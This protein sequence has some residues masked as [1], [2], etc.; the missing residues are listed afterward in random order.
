MNNKL[1]K[2]FALAVITLPLLAIFI[3]RVNS[4]EA[5]SGRIV[6]KG[7]DEIAEA[8]KKQCALCHKAT[9]EKFFNT[10]LKDEELVQA[11][12]KGKKAEKPP[13]MPEFESKGVT[14]EKAKLFVD[15]MRKLRTPPS[16]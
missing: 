11:I 2:L 1:I 9:A 14:E 8:Y 10:E 5:V 7:E 6:Q 16:E 4:V 15:Y 3:F 12:L 13:H